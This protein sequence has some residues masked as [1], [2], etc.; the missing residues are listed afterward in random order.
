M[1]QGLSSLREG[2]GSWSRTLALG[3]GRLLLFLLEGNSL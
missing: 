1:A 3:L 2:D